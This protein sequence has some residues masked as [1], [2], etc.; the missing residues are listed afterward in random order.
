M[1]SELKGLGRS[2]S[3]FISLLPLLKTKVGLC[4]DNSYPHI[5]LWVFGAEVFP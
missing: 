2:I 3:Y 1:Y 5:P 4:G